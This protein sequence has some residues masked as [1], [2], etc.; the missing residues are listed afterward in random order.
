MMLVL[1]LF[2][3]ASWFVSQFHHGGDA[4]TALLLYRSLVSVVSLS[5]ISARHG[6]CG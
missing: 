5:S 3:D 6:S 4:L 2:L 1:G